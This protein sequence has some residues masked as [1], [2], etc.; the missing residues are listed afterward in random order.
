VFGIV[1]AVM[2]G[3]KRSDLDHNG[4]LNT[5][6]YPQQVHEVN[7]YNSLRTMSTVG[8]VVGAVGVAG[9]GVLLLTSPRR[10]A[11][12][13]PLVSPWVGVGSGGVAGRF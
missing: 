8:F 6:C 1:T 9:G 5:H 7:S 10:Q 4:C 12:L 11:T 3:S 13:K 2:A